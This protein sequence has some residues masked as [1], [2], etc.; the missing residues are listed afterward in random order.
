MF[1]TYIIFC[2]IGILLFYSLGLYFEEK[3]NKYSFAIWLYLCS[4]FCS[5]CLFTGIIVGIIR[6]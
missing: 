2:L 5:I 3:T 6:G 1:L 4:I